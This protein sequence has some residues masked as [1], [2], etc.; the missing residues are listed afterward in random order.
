M[1]TIKELD[2]YILNIEETKNTLLIKAINYYKNMREELY[3]FLEDGHIDISNNLAERTVKPFVIARKNFLFCKT[4]D[5]AIATGKAFSIVQT[6][7]A[8]G[9][10]VELYLKYAIESIDKVP[11]EDLLPW[12]KN[13]PDNLKIIIK[14]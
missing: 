13:L 1:N 2:D 11:I 3:T 10:N 9:L 6:A 12:S 14:K 7:R 4:A 5:G 8:N